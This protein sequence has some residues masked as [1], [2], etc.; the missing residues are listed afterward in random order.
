MAKLCWATNADPRTRYKKL[1]AFWREQR[2]PQVAEFF[3]K[4][5]AAVD[6]RGI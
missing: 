1:A 5:A 2:L 4:A 3:E 6:A